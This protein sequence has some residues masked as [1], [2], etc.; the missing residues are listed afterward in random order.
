MSEPKISIIIPIYKVEKYLNRCLESVVNQ[1]YRNLEI[2]LVDDGSPDNCP[3]MCDA[4]AEKDSRIKVIHKENA[5]VA[6]ARNDALDIASGEFIGFVDSDDYIELNMLETLFENIKASS[7]DVSVCDYSDNEAAS[8]DNQFSYID[9]DEALKGIASGGY[10]YSVLWNK[11]YKRSVIADV[12]MPDYICCEDEEFNYFVFQKAKTI[13]QCDAKLYHYIQTEELKVS[14]DYVKGAFGAYYAKQIIIENTPKTSV[15][16]PY[17]VQGLVFSSFAVLTGCILNN[18]ADEDKQELID[19]IL[20]YKK[21]IFSSKLFS[22][23]YKM[24]TLILN[25][26][27]RLYERIIR[28]RKR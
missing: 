1:T 17:A 4:W 16:Y 10:L 6:K 15:I 18:V 23:R 25:F 27:P 8:Q 19:T 26:S 22:K 24:R 12:R 14:G 21:L 2:I 11:L 13:V 3:A 20:I 28:R 7:A 5:G 9:V